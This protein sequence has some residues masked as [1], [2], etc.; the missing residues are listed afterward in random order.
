MSNVIA[1]PVLRGYTFGLALVIAVKQWPLL[2]NVQAHSGDFFALITE[3]AREYRAWHLPSLACG[4]ISLAGLFLLEHVPRVPGALLVIVAGILAA[5]ALAA[6][7]VALTGPIHLTLAMPSF[8]LPPGTHA[9]AL[10]EFSIAVTFILYAE[11][12]GSIRTFALKHDES[13]QPNRDLLAL[14]VANLVSGIF[15][16][17]P[18]GAGY[19]GTSANDAA[20]A[21]SRLAGL[22]AAAVVLVLVLVFLGWIERIPGP[23]LAAIVVHA[24]SKSLRFSVFRHYFTWRRDR[25][26]AVAAVLAVMILGVLN[27][28]LAAIAL[29]I[30]LLLRSLAR[31]R[32]SILGRVGQ[33]D[34]VNT[35]VYPAA[36]TAPGTLVLRPEEP[37]F[38]ANAEPLLSQVRERVSAAPTTRLVVLSLE[39][40]P[41]LDSTSLEAL[42]ELCGWLS[43]HDVELRLARLKDSARDALRR[44][45]LE[46]LPP[47]ALHYA[48]VD[49]AV[50]GQRVT[51]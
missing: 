17:T 37:L 15:H 14:G 3:L 29:T 19:S 33:H 50:R 12:Y 46:Q 30:A 10:V 22:I 2:V 7:G 32:L 40:S 47:D 20:G 6:H 36:A 51:P 31:P 1:R 8:A 41:D 13:V 25:L 35:A 26:V 49:D 23:S 48:S 4:L 28:L 45:K 11:S 42:A 18:V 27:G 34:Y 38:F 39:E 21:Q 5:P 9:L 16:G 44:A 24:V 43:R